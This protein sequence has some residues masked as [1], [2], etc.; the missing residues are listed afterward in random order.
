MNADPTPGG[1]ADPGAGVGYARAVSDALDPPKRLDV[2]DVVRT[3]GQ[4]MGSSLPAL[5]AAALIANLP[6]AVAEVALARWRAETLLD[7]V[8]GADDA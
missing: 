4:V 5:F 7:L 3:S 2:G 6:T 1:G 8:T